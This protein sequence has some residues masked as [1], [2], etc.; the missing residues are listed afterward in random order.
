MYT[1]YIQYIGYSLGHHC[2]NLSCHSARWAFS[3]L[4]SRPCVFFVDVDAKFVVILVL[5]HRC[6]EYLGVKVFSRENASGTSC[7]SQYLGFCVLRDT[8]STRIISGLNTLDTA[9]TSSI[10]G[11]DALEYCCT[12]SILEFGTLVYCLYLKYSGI[13][14]CSYFEYSQYFGI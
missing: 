12:W 10:L 8:A 3:N 5:L 13:L 14:C 11:F 4:E 9:C 7:T 1:E 6:S 2:A